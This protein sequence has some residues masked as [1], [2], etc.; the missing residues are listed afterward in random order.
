[1]QGWHLLLFISL[2]LNG[3][4]NYSAFLD[5]AN[6]QTSWVACAHALVSEAVLD[7]IKDHGMILI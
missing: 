3:S 5:A 7:L 6:Y 4:A 1:M 2:A